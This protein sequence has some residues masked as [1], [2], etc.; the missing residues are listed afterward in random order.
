MVSF[1]GQKKVPEPL[2]TQPSKNSLRRCISLVIS[3]SLQ[4]KSVLTQIKKQSYHCIYSGEWLHQEI[5]QACI[6][7]LVTTFPEAGSSALDGKSPGPGCSKL[8]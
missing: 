1:R 2:R 7:V 6:V 3:G 5:S 8:G 4:R